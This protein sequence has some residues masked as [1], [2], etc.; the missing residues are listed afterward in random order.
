MSEPE[1]LDESFDLPE[2]PQLHTF[3]QVEGVNWQEILRDLT[4]CRCNLVTSKKNSTNS[5]SNQFEF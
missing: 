1:L 2:N 4:V 5:K 3:A